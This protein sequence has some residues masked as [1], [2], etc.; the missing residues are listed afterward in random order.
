MLADTGAFFPFFHKS[1]SLL[2]NSSIAAAEVFENASEAQ[3]QIV[4]C[5]SAEAMVGAAS[6]FLMANLPPAD[7]SVKDIAAMFDTIVSDRKVTRVHHLVS[8]FGTSERSLQRLFRRYVG[9]SPRWVIKRYRA[10]EALDHL[11]DPQPQRLAAVAQEL[12]YF[13][14]AHFANDFKNR[15]GRAPAEYTEDAMRVETRDSVRS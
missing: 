12:G 7:P 15:V 8:R 6:K 9:A 3:T 5:R 11:N 10:Y 13:D 14:Q 1:V 2:S 4:N